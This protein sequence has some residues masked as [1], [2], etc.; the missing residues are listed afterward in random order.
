MR[1]L[2]TG[3]SGLIGGALAP[4]L[5]AAG[6]DVVRFARNPLAAPQADAIHTDLAKPDLAALAGFDAVIHLA[7]ESIARR[8]TRR[9]KAAILASRKD[10]TS[11]LATALAKTSAPPAHFL[12]ASGVNYYSSYC[13]TPTTEDAPSGEGFLAEVCRQWESA[14][15]PLQ[16]ASRIAHLRLAPVLT[17]RGGALAQMLPAFRFGGGAVMGDG[18]QIMSW[19]A[20]PDAL[21]AFQHVLA[22]PS[23]VGPVNVCSPNVVTN[24]EFTRTLARVLHRPAFLRIPKF[25][26]R[27]A[28]GQ[29]ADETILATFNIVPAKLLASH[30]TFTQPALDDALRSSLT[31]TDY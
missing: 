26:L 22:T 8:W 29:M 6:H 16:N 3:A 12:A 17:P 15:A 14:S 28:F 10:F 5:R 19:I 23:L 24:R 11:A 9:R 18:R 25:A 30:F 21:R 7:G 4:E 1:I 20:L 27:L 31:K 2:L 13:P